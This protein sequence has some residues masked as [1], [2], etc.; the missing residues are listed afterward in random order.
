MSLSHSTHLPRALLLLPPSAQ[1][2]ILPL[3]S[4]PSYFLLLSVSSLTSFIPLPCPYLPR[5]PSSTLLL[6][7][8]SFPPSLSSFSPLLLVLTLFSLPLS[9]SLFSLSSSHALLLSPFPHSLPCPSL[10]LPSPP[11]PFIS[12]PSF[13]PALSPS[14]PLLLSQPAPPLSP[15]LLFYFSFLLCFSS[16]PHALPLLFGSAPSPL[17]LPFLHSLFPSRSPFS[18]PS[19]LS[20][21]SLFF[22]LSPSS[23]PF[24]IPPPLS[25]PF[26]SPFYFLSPLCLFVFY[27]FP[28]R[29]LPLSSPLSSFSPL[30]IFNLP[31]SS[32]LSFLLPFSS[33]SFLSGSPYSS[34]SFFSLPS[35]SLLYQ[36]SP[37]ITTSV[38]ITFPSLSP[39]PLPSSPFPFP[40]PLFSSPLFSPSFPLSPSSSSFRILPLLLFSPPF[41][42]SPL[43]FS[44][45]PLIPFSLP[46]CFLPPL[47]SH[48][49]PLLSLP[50]C[51]SLPQ[52]TTLITV[53]VNKTAWLPI[54]Y[55]CQRVP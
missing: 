51:L 26:L 23:S 31:L 38:S 41:L 28:S 13:P 5:F 24:I 9:F 10:S 15:F 7:P 43:C 32:L 44:V 27:F 35:V 29:F 40:F 25:P 6:S 21:L 53:I 2:A 33:L 52:Y 30:F 36:P 18:P 17:F 1:L 11:S 46:P 39:S 3:L 12:S 34:L 49:F 20:L 4:P 37:L 22:L 55:Q 19:L 48:P 47:L 8:P 16:S 54:A 50:S 14:S 42:P 45:S